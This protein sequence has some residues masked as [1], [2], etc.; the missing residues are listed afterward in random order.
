MLA[1]FDHFVLQ[2]A[3]FESNYCAAAQSKPG[4]LFVDP[5]RKARGA[6]AMNG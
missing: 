5:E 2:T 1:V 6:G 4:S 3:F